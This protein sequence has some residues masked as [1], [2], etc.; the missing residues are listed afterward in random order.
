MDIT[1][2]TARRR[3][4]SLFFFDE[5]IK[6][7]STADKEAQHI[8]EFVG[9]SDERSMRQELPHDCSPAVLDVLTRIVPLLSLA[10]E[11]VGPRF[12]WWYG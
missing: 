10:D 11:G 8:L 5:R 7:M 12:G 2:T 6:Q 1:T 3:F 9:R 4:V